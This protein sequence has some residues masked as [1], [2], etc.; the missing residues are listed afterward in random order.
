MA[1]RYLD[2]FVCGKSMKADMK[3]GQR[4]RCPHCKAVGTV[5]VEEICQNCRFYEQ[6]RDAYYK[7]RTTL[8]GKKKVWSTP[9]SGKCKAEAPWAGAIGSYRSAHVDSRYPNVEGNDWCGRFQAR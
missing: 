4:V 1:I 8:F 9:S 7:E 2:C 6:W 5:A 3:E